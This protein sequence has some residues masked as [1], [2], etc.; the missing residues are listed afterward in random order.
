MAKRTSLATIAWTLIAVTLPACA[1][2]QETNESEWIPLL[3]A[4]ASAWRGYLK[5]D[6]PSGWQVLGGALT[7]VADAGDI[8]TRDTFENFE[9]RLEYKVQRGGNSGIFFGVKEDPALRYA[10]LSGAEFQV[11]DNAG[12]ADG[13]N[14]L[15]S[16]GSNFAL[17]APLVNVARPAGEWNE[18]RLIVNKGHVE[19]WMNGHKVLEYD[20]GS[21]D[22]NSRV[23]ASKFRDMPEYG[24]TRRGN[25]ALQDHGDRVA[26]QRI[27]I[28]R[29]D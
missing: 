1:M 12:H 15:T 9:L 3:D 22:W 29:L 18:V 25:I 17:H 20:L 28:R 27:R 13:R 6:L 8:I 10:Y 26:F 19:H 7:R 5:P 24:K 2:N 21:T 23:A 4:E 11:L 14:P 16:A